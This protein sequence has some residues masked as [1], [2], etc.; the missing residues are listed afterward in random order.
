MAVVAKAPEAKDNSSATNIVVAATA[1]IPERLEAAPRDDGFSTNVRIKPF[2]GVPMQYRC[3]KLADC[4]GSNGNLS[5]RHELGDGSS[6]CKGCV[7]PNQK[8]DLPNTAAGL[9]LFWAAVVGCSPCKGGTIIQFRNHR[10]SSR[11]GRSSYQKQ[12]ALHGAASRN[13]LP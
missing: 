3:H 12:Q 11:S 13:P 5:S 9:F 7:R 8:R 10:G 4:V 6:C 2:M 1:A